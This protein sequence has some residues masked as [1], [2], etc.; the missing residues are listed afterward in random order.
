MTPEQFVYWLQ[1]MFEGGDL[2]TLDAKQTKV[3]KNHL[4]LVFQHIDPPDPDGSLHAAHETGEVA[5]MVPGKTNYL[6]KQTCSVCK[7]DWYS[8]PHG[9]NDSRPRC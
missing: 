6:Q 1:G 2:E 9:K 4:A 3:V 7:T 8:C 5:H